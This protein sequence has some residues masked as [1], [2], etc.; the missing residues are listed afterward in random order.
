M[1]QSAYVVKCEEA[2]LTEGKD[3]EV[4]YRNNKKPG[5]ASITFKGIGNYTGNKKVNFKINKGIINKVSLEDY[6]VEYAKGGAKPEIIVSSDNYPLTEGID[7]TVKY[8]GN[9]VITDGNTAKATIKG[10]GYFSNTNPVDIYYAVIQKTV[11][12]GDGSFELTA[13]DK[14]LASGKVSKVSKLLQIPKIKD[15]ATGKA[16]KKSTDYDTEINYYIGVDRDEMIYISSDDKKKDFG[17]YFK[18]LFPDSN[19]EESGVYIKAE[20]KLAG[21]FTGSYSTIYRVA[22]SKISSAKADIISVTYTGNA[23]EF[24]SKS[25]TFATDFV[26]YVGKN[27]SSGTILEYGTDYKIVE[28]SYK[29]NIKKGKATVTIIGLGKYSGTKNVSF[30]IVSKKI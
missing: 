13:A 17:A 21:Y 8:S 7:Y 11:I 3:F 10:K 20:Y 1:I 6:N 15:S 24:D 23:F 12:D 14:N 5:T 4:E 26:I 19:Y 9:T 30:K 29:D 16:L 27:K 18:E 2:I 28:G 25:P 22:D